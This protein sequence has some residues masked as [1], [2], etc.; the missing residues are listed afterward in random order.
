M[1]SKNLA[2]FITL[3]V[4]LIAIF[5]YGKHFLFQMDWNLISSATSPD[6]SLTIRH[7]QSH[8]EAGHAPYGDNLVIESW[9]S[10]PDPKAGETFFA[11]YCGKELS[12][13][14]EGNEKIVI[15]CP[16][17]TSQDPIRTQ[18]IIVH[19]VTVEVDKQ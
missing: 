5:F 14:W 4:V 11:G 10:F 13:K 12:F 3:L 2:I 6:G 9:R 16:N 17:I 8:T 15:R 18:A 7:F 1:K 19:G